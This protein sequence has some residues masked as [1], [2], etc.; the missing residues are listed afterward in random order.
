MP[1]FEPG[2]DLGIAAGESF[3]Q[4]FPARRQSLRCFAAWIILKRCL[5][6]AE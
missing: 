1:L 2:R 5:H 6:V 3:H 4:F